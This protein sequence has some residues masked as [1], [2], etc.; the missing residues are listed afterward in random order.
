MY[1]QNVIAV[2]HPMYLALV[3]LIR[4]ALFRNYSAIASGTNKDWDYTSRID[5]QSNEAEMHYFTGMPSLVL[6]MQT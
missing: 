1:F 4:L 6:L 3:F 5:F 2:E